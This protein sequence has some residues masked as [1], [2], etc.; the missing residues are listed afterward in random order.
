METAHLEAAKGTEE[1][2]RQYCSKDRVDQDWGEEGDFNP[3]PAQGRRT[4]LEDAVET[5][6]K[7]GLQGVQDQHPQVYV[8]YHAGLAKLA[9]H[10][11]EKPPVTREVTTMILWGQPGVGKSWRVT[12]KYPD[13][14]K[15]YPGRDPFGDYRG[16]PV[17]VFD[18]FDYDHWKMEQMNHYLDIYRLRLDCR[19]SNK[20]ARWSI[21]IIISNLDPA[22]WWQ[23]QCEVKKA[24]F[25]RRIHKTVEVLDR[26]Q[27]II[28]PDENI[29]Q[30]QEI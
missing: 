15:V 24:A 2:N 11:E 27:E 29:P 8:K 1:Q 7:E 9:D 16:E 5:L 10:W 30:T 6:K 22:S 18:E 28:L 17:I 23:W 26:T 3:G 20:W 19:Y 12:A 14:Y 13:A 4:D 25:M 21:V